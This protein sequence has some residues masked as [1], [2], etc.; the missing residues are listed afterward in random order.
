MRIMFDKWLTYIDRFGFLQPGPGHQTSGNGIMYSIYL[1]L[2]HE[3]H[4]IPEQMAK[5]RETL[6][7]CW[8]PGG[9]MNRA[10][11]GH[12][13]THLQQADDYVGLGL[14]DLT[15]KTDYSRR[16][17]ETANQNWGI[18]NNVTPGKFRWKAW[19]F[20]MP[21]VRFHLQLCAGQKPGPLGVAAWSLSLLWSLTKLK[22]R[23]SRIKAWIM[24]ESAYRTVANEH[25]L[26][27]LVCAIWVMGFKKKFPG[28]GAAE[29]FPI[30]H[31][32]RQYFWSRMPQLK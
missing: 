1:A 11:G 32:A 15:M 26:I 8:V 6:D 12:F 4:P 20:R 27:R 31:P 25:Q 24:V 5:L 21:Q 9:G 14:L 16:L 19:I 10:P 30:D 28:C 23:D 3:E 17:L 7:K 22:H 13:S 2:Y 18:L 29:Y